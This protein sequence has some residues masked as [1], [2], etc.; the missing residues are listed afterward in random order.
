MTLPSSLNSTPHHQVSVVPSA[1]FVEVSITLTE[2]LQLQ[3]RPKEAIQV[4]SKAI[5]EVNT[6]MADMRQ[7]K[8]TAKSALLNPQDGVKTPP[9]P[10]T[11]PQKSEAAVLPTAEEYEQLRKLKASCHRRIGY[12]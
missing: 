3:G 10:N 9:R 6:D 7:R 11:A 8:A 4:L 1:R 2:I 12:V 5:E